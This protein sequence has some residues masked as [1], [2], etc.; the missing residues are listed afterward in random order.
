MKTSLTLEDEIRSLLQES[1]W[2]EAGPHGRTITAVMKRVSLLRRRAVA[3]E[4]KLR[5]VR[6]AS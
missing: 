3:K 6:Q 2:R 1:N 4:R 5:L